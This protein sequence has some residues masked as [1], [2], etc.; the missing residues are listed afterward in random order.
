MTDITEYI[1][2]QTLK[3]FESSLS[4]VFGVASIILNQFGMSHSG[5][6]GF[7]KQIK[8]CMDTDA[9]IVEYMR[10]MIPTIVRHSEPGYSSK[11]NCFDGLTVYCAPIKQGSQTVGYLAAGFA[12]IG[13]KTIPEENIISEETADKL[14]KA[15]YEIA[16]NISANVAKSAEMKQMTNA[17]LKI[18]EHRSDFLANIS[19]EM[20]T[21]LNA[22]IGTAEIALR[23]DMSDE[24]REYLHQIKSSA[25]HLLMIINDILDFS[26][27]ETGEMSIVPVDYELLSLIN[28]VAGIVNN[29]IG[30]KNIEFTIDVPPDLP[31]SLKGDNVR[32]QQVLINLLNNAVKFTKSGNVS[33]K[34]STRPISDENVMLIASVSDTG[35]GI[36]QENIGRLFKMFRQ[37]DSKRN[38]NVEGTGLG[39]AISKKLLG[40]MGGTISVESEPGKGSTF[41]FEV[42]QEITREERS[43]AQS[44]PAGT[45]V[46]LLLGNQYL[47]QSVETAVREIG[48]ETVS[49]DNHLLGDKAYIIADYE[50]FD[51]AK[52]LIVRNPGLK[53]ILID[54]FDSTA[55]SDNENITIIRKPVYSF[56]LSAAMGIGEKFVRSDDAESNVSFTAPEAYVLIVD[57]NDINRAVAKGVIEPLG[58]QVDL[59]ASGAECI[60]KVRNFRYDITFMDHMMPEMDGIEAAHIIKHRFPSYADVPIIALMFLREGMSDFIAKPISLRTIANKIRHWLPSEKIIPVSK[61]ENKAQPQHILP[62]IPE[63]DLRSAKELIGS[64]KLLLNVIEQYYRSV[65]KNIAKINASY[66]NGN[67]E[68]LTIEFHSLK[69]TSKQI[70]ANKLSQMAKDLEMAGKNNNNTYIKNNI[71]KFLD[72][73]KTMKNVLSAYFG[74]KDNENTENQDI[75]PLLDEL[76]DALSDMDALQIDDVLEK[77]SQNTSDSEKTYFDGIKA[78][79]DDCDFDKAESILSKWN[80]TLQG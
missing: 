16:I 8:E 36:S 27:I 45:V 46:C 50:L 56:S 53:C 33:L 13:E 66:E 42:P 2:A 59:A 75:K 37:I 73:Y 6:T 79:I 32:I 62:D 70:G 31:F 15:V 7:P 11:G 55:Y 26:K 47:R 69:S 10:C 14:S 64:E 67:T 48:A 19:H 57:D 51:D 41:T 5:G 18:A 54:R 4:S 80:S 24:M 58:M 25:H 23:R 38:R 52:E 60:E 1:S 21:P 3:Q 63:L 28:D 17:A 65:D 61:S 72:E 49:I 78:A 43:V 74:N 39:L 12:K 30:S 9:G 40:L 77:I 68:L 35:C 29:Q 34:I 71:E 22:V 44:A 76:S 20:R